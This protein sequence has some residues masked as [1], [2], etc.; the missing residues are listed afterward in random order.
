VSIILKETDA[1]LEIWSKFGLS[2]YR[3]ENKHAIRIFVT[4]VADP[5]P[6]WI[7]IQESKNDPQK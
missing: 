3:N 1:K 4:R 6:N 7:R 5:D 2:R